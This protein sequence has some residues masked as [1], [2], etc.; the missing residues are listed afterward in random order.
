MISKSKIEKRLKQKKNPILVK[1][2]IKLKKK[3]PEV[4]KILAGP[5]KKSIKLNLKDLNVKAKEGENILVPGKVLGV[6]ELGKKLKVV[7]WNASKKAIE[8]IS[9]KGEY[10]S[11]SDELKK[12][13]SLSGLKMVKW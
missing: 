2:L 8:K 13:P 3:N 11:I 7:S 6:G 10:V 1:T 4:A 5:N 9:E 12:N